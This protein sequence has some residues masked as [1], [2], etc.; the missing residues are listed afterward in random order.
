M[1]PELVTHTEGMLIS[2]ALCLFLNH[3]LVEVE[4]TYRSANPTS[5]SQRGETEAKREEA[6]LLRTRTHANAFPKKLDL[7]SL[8]EQ[9]LNLKQGHGPDDLLRCVLTL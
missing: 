3:K 1:G 4:E 8:A 6:A 5:W 9:W 2:K 7:V